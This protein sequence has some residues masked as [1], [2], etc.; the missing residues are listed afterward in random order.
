MATMKIEL[1]ANEAQVLVNLIDVA[2]KAAG[3]QAAEAGLHFKKKI[4][5]A[6]SADVPADDGTKES[7]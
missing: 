1:D 4:D 2:V 3:L 5:A 6:A 7:A